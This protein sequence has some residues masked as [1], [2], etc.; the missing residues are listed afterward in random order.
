MS[1]ISLLRALTIGALAVMAAQSPATAETRLDK[2]SFGTNWVAEAEHGGF[3]QA[4]A[5]GT[6]KNYGLDVTIVPGGP[7]VNNRI[8]LISGKLDFFMSANTLQ[9]FDAVAN[10]VPVVAVAAIFQ[11]DPQVFL[12]HP[13]PKVTKLEDLK[14]MTLLISK[15]GVAGYFQWMRSELGFSASKVKPYTYNAQP[16][17]VDKN[18]AMQGYVTSEPF[19]VEKQANFKP[20]VMLLADYGFD[21]YSTLIETRREWVDKKPD[22]VQRFVDASMIGWYNYLY[23][24]NKAANEVIKKL[25]PEMTDD[26]LAYSIAKMKEYG[27]VDSGDTLKDGIGAMSEARVASF[28]D[29]MSRAG[30]VKRDIDYRKAYTLQFINKGVGLDLRPKK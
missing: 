11:K 10:N 21:G 8:L 2:V 19:V 12:A 13:N 16:F 1:P 25:N 20:T 6:Y 24:D 9:S 30:V 27:I 28:F 17:I 14:P 3:F 5:D 4:V 29:K 22:L 18:S 7:N 26:L 15:E 23:G